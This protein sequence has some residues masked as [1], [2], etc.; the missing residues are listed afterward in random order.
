[1]TASDPPPQPKHHLRR[2]Q[3]E[4][5]RSWAGDCQ[6][7]CQPISR[8]LEEFARHAST[9]GLRVA[10]F[11]PHGCE[12]D[13]TPLLSAHRDIHWVFPR[14]VEEMLVLHAV[15][16]LTDLRPGAFGILEPQ[17]QAPIVTP[18]QVDVFLCPGLAFDPTGVRLGRGKGYYDRLLA[19]AA[20]SAL[21]IGVG[22][23]VHWV[24]SLPAEAHDIRMHRICC[25]SRVVMITPQTTP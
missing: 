8:W 12:P 4:R 1:M 18:E 22:L 21:R 9:A 3:R 17:P 20:P 13:L 11:H 6:T 14:V 24:E 16:S 23:D 2:A 19:Q 10:T 5:Q 15:A 25:G 7:P